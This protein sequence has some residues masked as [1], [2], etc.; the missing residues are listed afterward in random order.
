MSLT[1]LLRLSGKSNALSSGIWYKYRRRCGQRRA[2][3]TVDELDSALLGLLQGDARKSNKDLARAL[4]IAESTCLERVR[5]LFKRGIIRGSHADVDLKKIGRPVQAMVAVRLRPPDRTVIE[6]FHSFV[7][8]LPETLSVF[9]MSGNDDFLIHI[10]VQ[11]NDH[12]N[13]F[14]LDQ[15]TKRKEIVDVRTSVIF[16]HHRR[17]VIEPIL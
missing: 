10:A 7:T 11:D 4:H 8:E 6:A 5:S 1:I 9:I 15:L 14:I 3:R 17:I 12:L 16:R 2:G 13:D